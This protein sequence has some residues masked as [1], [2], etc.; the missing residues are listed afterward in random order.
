MGFVT[1]GQ[2]SL[3]EGLPDNGIAGQQ[4][5]LAALGVGAMEALRHICSPWQASTAVRKFVP[6]FRRV[7]TGVEGRRKPGDAPVRTGHPITLGTTIRNELPG[8][9]T[10]GSRPGPCVPRR[11]P[12]TLLA[13]P[14]RPAT[15]ACH[16]PCRQRQ[17]SPFPC[18]RCPSHS[19]S[20]AARTPAALVP[21]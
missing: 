21:A 1:R 11:T 3:A 6:G 18:D 13:A 15:A 12:G 20:D 4:R 7:D 10:S 17:S 9:R 16:A 5:S 2:D 19:D 14:A 8:C